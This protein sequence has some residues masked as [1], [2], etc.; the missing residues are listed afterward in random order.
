MQ[1]RRL[2]GLLV[3]GLLLSACGAQGPAV[4]VRDPWVRAATMGDTMGGGH[5]GAT[6]ITTGTMTMGDAHGG[7]H[8]G[9]TGT[10]TA[11]MEMGHGGGG[12]VSAAYFTIANSSGTADAL[13]RAASDV[14]ETV[15]LHTV[16]MQNDVMQMRPVNQ[17]DI[18]A[19]G[20]VELKP[21]GFH[22][23]LIG[24]KRDLKVGDTVN[25]TLTLQ[26]AGT[27]NVAATV[28]Q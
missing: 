24:L 8:G 14:A 17:I 11:T 2:L 20:E 22:V 12:A 6:S 23:M 7:A 10:T 5:G 18:P 15:E 25:L 4:S 16:E 19:R 1:K 21:G 27:L 9:A 13:V 26:N 28:R 3:L